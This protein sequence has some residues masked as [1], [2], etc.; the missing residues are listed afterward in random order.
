[1]DD[2]ITVQSSLESIELNDPSD[3]IVLADV[4]LPPYRDEAANNAVTK[5]CTLSK[6]LRDTSEDAGL[7]FSQVPLLLKS[8]GDSF[9]IF[10]F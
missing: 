1:M 9:I 3:R 4:Y 2:A 7:N 6:W 8:G 5:N 10:F